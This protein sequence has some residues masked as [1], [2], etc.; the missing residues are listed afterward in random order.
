MAPLYVFMLPSLCSVKLLDLLSDVE[1]E[2]KAV[3]LAQQ[4]EHPRDK[5]EQLG[6]FYLVHDRN[7]I[8]C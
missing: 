6:Q 3:S 8:I 2:V 1:W 7:S 4:R 5:E